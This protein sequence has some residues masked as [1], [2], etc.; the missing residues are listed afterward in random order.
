MK[1]FLSLRAPLS[2]FLLILFLCMLLN[3]C[4]TT[5]ENKFVVT[6]TI[7]PATAVANHSLATPGNEVQFSTKFTMT[8]NC[9]LPQNIVAGSWSI[10]SPTKISLSKST[11][12]QTVA[13]CLGT[14]SEAAVISYSGTMYGYSFTPATLTCE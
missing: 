14:T 2:A 6:A 8:G 13:T 5:S 12:T 11:S 10:S 1:I 4:G 3:G 9:A 7:T